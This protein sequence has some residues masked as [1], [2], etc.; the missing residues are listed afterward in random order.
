MH[1]IV[2]VQVKERPSLLKA[3][4]RVGLWH[5]PLIGDRVFL[6]QVN[7]SIG[8]LDVPLFKD[9]WYWLCSRPHPP[10]QANKLDVGSL[11]IKAHFSRDLIYPLRAYDPLTHMLLRGLDTPVSMSMQHVCHYILNMARYDP[12]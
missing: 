2:L 9:G 12:H 10:G 11:R 5:D 8:S 7:L 3:V 1:Y 6:G 4:V